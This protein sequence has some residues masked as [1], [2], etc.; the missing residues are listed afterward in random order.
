M[1]TILDYLNQLLKVNLIN[2]IL[3]DFY[4]IFGS[5]ICNWLSCSAFI[6]IYTHKIIFWKVLSWIIFIWTNKKKILFLQI[7][8]VKY[9]RIL[10]P[11]ILMVMMDID[12]W[13]VRSVISHIE[14][15][16][17]VQ[18]VASWNIG[19]NEILD[20]V[21]SYI[22]GI[23]EKITDTYKIIIFSIVMMHDLFR[24]YAIRIPPVKACTVQICETAFVETHASCSTNMVVS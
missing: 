13:C 11:Q 9:L 5:S 8:L 4:K 14:A 18:E 21:L 15:S 1:L 23:Y 2:L 24:I 10:I 16:T 22:Y 3:E 6:I 7:I 17:S 20:M 12:N 19:F